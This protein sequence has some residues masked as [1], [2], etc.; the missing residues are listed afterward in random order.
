MKSLLAVSGIKGG[1]SY[2]E[3]LRRRPGVG[4]QRITG[5]PLDVPQNFIQ[6]K[7]PC[8]ISPEGALIL[9]PAASYSPGVSRPKYH[10]R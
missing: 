7:A 9:M 2:L 8:R 1:L 10:R 5:V 4:Y 6:R 3:H